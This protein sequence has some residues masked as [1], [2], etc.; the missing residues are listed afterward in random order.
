MWW[1]ALNLFN[2]NNVLGGGELQKLN[3]FNVIFHTAT[4]NNDFF[5]V[6]GSNVNEFDNTFNL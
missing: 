1:M 3:N 6:F 4:F 2:R 5:I